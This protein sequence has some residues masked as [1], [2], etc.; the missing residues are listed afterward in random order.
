[1]PGGFFV[2]PGSG[3]SCGAHWG[4]FPSDGL[5]EPGRS[6]RRLLSELSTAGRLPAGTS[7]HIRARGIGVV[8]GGRP[9]LSDVDE[10]TA[11]LRGTQAA[12]VA[13]HDR[14][15]LADLAFRPSL[16]LAVAPETGLSGDPRPLRSP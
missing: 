3:A 10:L 14:Q 8:L 6:I 13:T 7:A 2:L 5:P 4:A 15:M 12:V 1:M 16:S 9:V 11:V